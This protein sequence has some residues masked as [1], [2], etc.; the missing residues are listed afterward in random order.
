[1]SESEPKT[2]VYERKDKKFFQSELTLHRQALL[3]EELEPF[4]NSLMNVD[5]MKGIDIV[6]TLGKRAHWLAAIVLL[7]EGMTEEK[8]S[9]SVEN[10]PSFLKNQ[11]ILFGSIFKKGDF[12]KMVNDFFACNLGSSLSNELKVLGLTEQSQSTIGKILKEQQHSSR[13]EIPV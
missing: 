7:P 2:Y 10:S 6:I 13:E 11:S 1:M 3:L 9:E 8:W 12:L 4:K 5:G